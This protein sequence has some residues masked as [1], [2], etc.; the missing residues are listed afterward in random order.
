MVG[1]M[2]T[3]LGRP[4]ALEGALRSDEPCAAPRLLMLAS[5]GYVVV[6]AVILL[7][8]WLTLP[9]A[10]VAVSGA[11]AMSPA[12]VRLAASGDRRGW[13]FAL[14][15]GTLVAF[16]AGTV[17]ITSASGDWRKHRALLHD[18]VEYPWP[19]VLELPGGDAV[20]SYTTAW[21][22]PAALTGRVFGWTAA[23][24]ALAIWTA[25]G[26]AIIVWWAVVLVGSKVAAVGLLLFSGLDA[27]GALVL[28]QVSDWWAVGDDTIDTWPGEW[29]IPSVLRGLFE[30]P[31]HTLPAMILAGL[32]LSGSLSRLPVIVQLAVVAA[33]ATA[34]PFAAVGALPFVAFFAAR[35]ADERPSAPRQTQIGALAFLATT[36]ALMVPRLAGP[37]PGIPDE[38]TV[39]VTF[40]DPRFPQLGTTNLL[41]SFVLVVLLDIVVLAWLAT[42]GPTDARTTSLVH[43]ATATMVA[44]VVFRVGHNNDLAMRGPAVALFVL[45]VLS[46][47]SLLRIQGSRRIAALSLVAVAAITAGVEINRNLTAAPFGHHSF[48]N[49]DA[50]AGL[51]EM[52]EIWYPN[53]DSLL[54]QYLVQRTD[55]VDAVLAID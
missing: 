7:A 45:A 23:N 22:M 36:A 32:L 40:A 15:S 28:P 42:R 54:S 20:L 48:T 43:V 2:D 51:I 9:L 27:I 3:R 30:A 37:P 44:C 5:L 35:S 14:G 8:A 29:Q 10:L 4:A 13:R 24:A 52:A 25:I 53:R 46:T 33:A 11:L 18:L 21:Y 55:L 39:G 26:V 50:T 12:L 16:L 47:R 17:G 41:T 1:D 34:S 31:Q 49:P 38:V 19:T 6:P